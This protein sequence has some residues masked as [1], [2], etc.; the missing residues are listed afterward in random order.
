MLGF[1]KIS[2]LPE[3]NPDTFQYNLSL[4]DIGAVWIERKNGV[5]H[6]CFTPAVGEKI[7]RIMPWKDCP[8]RPQI[9]G[10]EIFW[11][12]FRNSRGTLCKWCLG[13]KSGLGRITVRPRLILTI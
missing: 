2:F 8:R 7:Q 4:Q 3:A 1:N 9:L 13:D 12:E 11:T 6:I 5:E 10:D